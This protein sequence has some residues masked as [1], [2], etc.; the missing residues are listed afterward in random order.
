M[1]KETLLKEFRELAGSMSYYNAAEGSWSKEAS[2][3]G[4]CA[5][6]LKLKAL[7]MLDNGFTLTDLDDLKGGF[8]LSQ[9]DYISNA[10]RSKYA[11]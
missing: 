5:A 2:A 8:L 10:D 1:S 4:K 9:T 11:N 3:R 7:E 6:D